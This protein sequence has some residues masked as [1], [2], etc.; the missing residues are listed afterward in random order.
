MDE[1]QDYYGL[2]IVE[3]HSVGNGGPTKAYNMFR[4]GEYE[5]NVIIIIYL[6]CNVGSSDFYTCDRSYFLQ[7]T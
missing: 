2:V 7:I 4:S 5:F 3:V 1:N 6:S